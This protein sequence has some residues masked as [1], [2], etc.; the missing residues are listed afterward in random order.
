MTK[1]KVTHDLITA[2]EATPVS[3]YKR[4]DEFEFRGKQVKVVEVIEADRLH[5]KNVNE[6]YNSF[7]VLVS[8][9][10]EDAKEPTEAVKQLTKAL[11]EAIDTFGKE[12]LAKAI[13]EASKDSTGD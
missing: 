11:D 3:L 13:V 10:K 4:G 5:V 6:P 7:I 1:K 2:D 12:R 8:E 9:I